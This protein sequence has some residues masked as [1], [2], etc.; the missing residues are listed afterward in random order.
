MVK[1]VNASSNGGPSTDEGITGNL[2]RGIDG[3]VRRGLAQGTRDAR[4]PPWSQG[5]G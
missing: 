2:A 4:D 3:S 5:L 1:G